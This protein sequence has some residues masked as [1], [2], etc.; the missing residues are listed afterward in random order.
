MKSQFQ[1]KEELEALLQ[2]LSV[3]EIARESRVTP[4]T[5]YFSM[6]RLGI[7]TPKLRAPAHLGSRREKHWHW[8]DGRTRNKDGY[9]ILHMPE[10]P[11]ADVNGYVLEHRLVMEK[12]L[13]R[14][15]KPWDKVHHVNGIKWD[16]RPENL[17][18]VANPHLGEVTCP[19]CD[20]K[21][22]IP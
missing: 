6:R 22:M 4:K 18:A 5:V 8:K 2:R 9:V 17:Q 19:R 12:I 3:E 7:P 10:H 20:Y 16:N 1:S 15:L 11:E 13:G 21:F 14:R